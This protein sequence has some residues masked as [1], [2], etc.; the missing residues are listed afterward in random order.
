MQT[1]PYVYLNYWSFQ[2][3]QANTKYKG[4]VM[5]TTREKIDALRRKHGVVIKCDK[6]ATEE[7]VLACLEALDKKAQEY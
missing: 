4:V 7:Q 6:N 2:S 5:S 3:L 1:C